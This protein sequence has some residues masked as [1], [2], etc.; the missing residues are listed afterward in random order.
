MFCVMALILAV[1]AEALGGQSGIV[2]E[3]DE[4]FSHSETINDVDY[5]YFR[6]GAEHGYWL[7][8]KNG[9]YSGVI[10]DSGNQLSFSPGVGNYDYFEF[11][12]YFLGGL[13]GDSGIEYNYLDVSMILDQRVIS[14]SF[15]FDFLLS[16]FR[17]PDGDISICWEPHV[18]FYDKDFKYLGVAE[19]PTNVI[20]TGGGTSG[21]SFSDTLEYEFDFV[22]PEGTVYVV[23]YQRISVNP[24]GSSFSDDFSITILSRGSWHI[25]TAYENLDKDDEHYQAVQDK[26]DDIMSGTPEQNEAAGDAMGELG[27]QKDQISDAVD[28]MNQMVKPDPS[29][30]SSGIDLVV[31]TDSNAA[32]L[33]VLGRI[34]SSTFVV[35]LMTICAGMWLCS[36]VLFGKRG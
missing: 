11:Y 23:P 7:V 16:W 10:S 3:L 29:G 13:Y 25:R 2:Y 24:G 26:L 1:P 27:N 6:F 12:Y 31:D 5:F 14:L 36:Y 8:N 34:S 19:A 4:F 15:N 32:Y 17:S 30:L 20:G 22:T 28:Q 33:G 21:S 18:K 9:I 35:S